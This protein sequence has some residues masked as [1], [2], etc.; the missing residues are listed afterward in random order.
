MDRNDKRKQ[1]ARHEDGE[2]RIVRPEQ[3]H[4]SD[5]GY[6]PQSEAPELRRRYGKAEPKPEKPQRGMRAPT[7][8]A[9][10]V[11]CVLLGGVAG[12]LA[13]GYMAQ[14][15]PAAPVSTPTEQ[16][17]QS[18]PVEQEKPQVFLPVAADDAAEAGSVGSAIYALGCAQTVGVTTEVSTRNIFGQVSTSSVTGS[19]FIIS[20]DGYILTNYHVIRAAHQGG[21]EISV[22]LHSGERFAAEIVGYESEGTDLAVLK[23]DAQGLSPV[24]A[25]VSAQIRVGEPVYAI[26]NPLG[27]LVYTMTT[28]SVSALD[29]EV[30][31]VD[32]DSGAAESV[33]F[34]QFDA[35]VNEG[36][37]GGPLFN[38]RGEVIGIV[39]A[40]Y[41]SAGVEGL[42]FALPIDEAM[43]LAQ[44]LIENGYVSGKAVLGIAGETVSEG[45]ARYYD[46][47]QGVYV[48]SV[49]KGSGAEKAG[50]RAGD[51]ITALGDT[52]VRS[53]G[54]LTLAERAYRAGDTGYLTV[55]RDGTETKI[56]VV[57]DEDVPK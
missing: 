8:V 26:G 22:M 39:T 4:Y 40:K 47:V 28:G 37:S 1:D 17:G 35:A 6:I 2:Y 52:P 33:H 27:E 25:G 24:T 3:A 42:G 49:A 15:A 20:E 38:A 54:E 12:G 53:T 14:R 30:V 18:R 19:G 29:R 36:N 51:I 5:A 16:S 55:Y 43:L 48:W 31:S 34:F 56:E 46:M 41:A 32:R 9:L 23:I 44:E 50:L 11:I 13:G 21:H 45:V 10:C 57:F 7:M